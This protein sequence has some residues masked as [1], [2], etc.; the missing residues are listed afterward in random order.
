MESKGFAIS[1]SLIDTKLKVEF[2]EKLNCNVTFTNQNSSFQIIIL[3][4]T[5]E[6]IIDENMLFNMLQVTNEETL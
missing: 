1:D 3:K 2:G 6:N 4:G 5:H